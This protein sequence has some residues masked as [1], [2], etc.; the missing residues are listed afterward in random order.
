MSYEERR[1]SQRRTF[2][3]TLKD[4]PSLEIKLNYYSLKIRNAH[5]SV[6]CSINANVSL[7]QDVPFELD[8]SV[9]R[10]WYQVGQTH[11]PYFRFHSP[12]FMII[13]LP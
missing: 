5:K 10:S 13:Y 7:Q 6:Y 12:V 1:S 4:I 8:R 9:G 11:K 2:Y 3:K